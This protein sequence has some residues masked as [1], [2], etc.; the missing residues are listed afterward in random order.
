MLRKPLSA[1]RT[2]AAALCLAA[3]L[4]VDCP[5]W[6]GEN[7]SGAPAL[8][9]EVPLPP[10]RENRYSNIDPQPD[11]PALTSATLAVP[12][13]ADAPTRNDRETTTTDAGRPGGTWPFRRRTPSPQENPAPAPEG[14]EP[15][16]ADECPPAMTATAIPPT[17][18]AVEA[19]RS[20]LE[21]RLLERY[22]NLPDFAGKVA[23]VQIVLSRP[24]E[25]SLDGGMIRAEFDQLVYDNWGKRLPA[26]EKEYYVVVF[27][28]GGAAQVRSEPSVRIG[29]DMEKTYSERA[30]LAADPFRNVPKTEAFRP[31]KQAKMPDWWRPEF[32]EL[33]P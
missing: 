10:P 20:K 26:L 19:Y 3:L 18:Q 1:S 4:A 23:R 8:L 14:L 6:A 33:E 25:V 7:R 31:A 17:P 32:P 24:P 22:N 28:S 27:G 16:A 13:K 29:L 30:P 9:Y 21:N 15:A 11:H 12:P 2:G 5:G